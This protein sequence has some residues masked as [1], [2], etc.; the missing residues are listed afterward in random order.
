[1]E[2]GLS[3]D[4]LKTLKQYQTDP[5][6]AA[7]QSE[8]TRQPERRKPQEQ[9]QPTTQKKQIRQKKQEKLQNDKTAVVVEYLMNSVHAPMHFLIYAKICLASGETPTFI[10]SMT[11]IHADRLVIYAT[12]ET[13]YLVGEPLD[14]AV[15]DRILK[16]KMIT[17]LEWARKHPRLA[18][19]LSLLERHYLKVRNLYVRAEQ[20]VP[21]EPK[22]KRK[23]KRNQK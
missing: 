21:K 8:Q 22:P 19:R 5:E 7:T 13:V 12:L 23:T 16:L 15:A 4:I 2:H 1:M 10:S 11:S 20:L 17:Y 9:K 3:K 18:R 6:K 14:N